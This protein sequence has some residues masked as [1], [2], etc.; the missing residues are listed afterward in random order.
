MLVLNPIALWRQFVLEPECIMAAGAPY[1]FET[2]PTFALISFFFFFPHLFLL[3]WRNKSPGSLLS[4]PPLDFR[5]FI[6]FSSI[7]VLSEAPCCFSLRLK[8]QSLL[9]VSCATSWVVIIIIITI[10]DAANWTWT[11]HRT[12]TSYLTFPGIVFAWNRLV[13]L[14]GGW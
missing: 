12:V 6:S 7:P 1:H 9:N 13:T 3:F 10:L 14:T 11:L 5:T 8:Y 2:A 4:L